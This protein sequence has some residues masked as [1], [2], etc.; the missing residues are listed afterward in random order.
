MVCVSSVGD[1]GVVG[2]GGSGVLLLLLLLLLLLVLLLLVLQ[3]WKSA[4]CGIGRQRCSSAWRTFAGRSMSG[5]WD[6]SPPRRINTKGI[7]TLS[8][9]TRGINCMGVWDQSDVVVDV[10]G[11]VD[12]MLRCCRRCW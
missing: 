10:G 9:A 6:A 11:V 3:V 5:H 4:L 2:V 7:S 8:R 1:S 12:V